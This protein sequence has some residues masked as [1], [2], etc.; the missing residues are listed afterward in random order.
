L[1]PLKHPL[2]NNT[3]INRNGTSLFIMHN[4][5]NLPIPIMQNEF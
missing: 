2:K 3:S 5:H 1:P 4:L